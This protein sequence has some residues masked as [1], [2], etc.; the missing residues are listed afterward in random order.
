[1]TQN[2]TNISTFRIL[3][4]SR[5]K[6]KKMEGNQNPKF[7]RAGFLECEVI[8]QNF[9]E[10]DLQNFD[11]PGEPTVFNFELTLNSFHSN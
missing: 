6:K 2:D 1:M 11:R 3:V 7:W 10:W 4:A 9:R 5:L 8:P